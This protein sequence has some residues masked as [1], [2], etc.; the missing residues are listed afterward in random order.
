MRLLLIGKNKNLYSLKRI[1]QEGKFYLNKNN[2]DIYSWK[3][4]EFYWE[5]KNFQ[6]KVGNQPLENYTHLLTRIAGKYYRQRYI[7]SQRAND[8]G[9]RCFNFQMIS[10]FVFYDKLIQFYF[11]SRAGLPIL[12]TCQF[13]KILKIKNNIQFNF[14]LILKESEGYQAKKVWKCNSQNQLLNQLK[15]RELTKN[16]IQPFVPNGYDIR[17][18]VI[19]NKVIGAYKRIALKNFKTT[20]KGKNINYSPSPEEKR[21]AIRAVSVLKGE[22]AGVDLI[23]QKERPKILEVNLDAGFKTFEEITKIN[24][25]KLILNQLLKSKN[26]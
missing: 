22:Y 7:L 11:L 15:K 18:L 2:I 6:I 4:I 21:L 5:E 1:S 10:K 24:V 13:L 8:L 26:D 16:L 17:I 23:Y 9:I 19:G 12:P 14:P 25:A 20:Q 3:D